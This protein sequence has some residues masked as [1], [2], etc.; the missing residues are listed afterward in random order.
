MAQDPR[1]LGLMKA[2]DYCLGEFDAD[3]GAFTKGSAWDGEP[4]EVNQA[5]LPLPSLVFICLVMFRGYEIGRA[6]V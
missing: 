2:L 4:I 6:H 5:Q 3:K 1:E